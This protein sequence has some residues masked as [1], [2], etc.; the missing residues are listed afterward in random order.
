MDQNRNS[1]SN[2]AMHDFGETRSYWARN[3][4]QTY[5]YPSTALVSFV[6]A[7]KSLFVQIKNLCVECVRAFQTEIIT[8]CRQTIHK[9]KNEIITPLIVQLKNSVQ[10]MI[11]TLRCDVLAPM[12]TTLKEMWLNVKDFIS[13]LKWKKDMKKSK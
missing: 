8:P 4:Y 7:I 2:Q 11:Q 10:S 6:T 13:S 1:Y 3:Q 5:C 9:M 12:Q